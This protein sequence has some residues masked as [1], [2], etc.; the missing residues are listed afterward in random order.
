MARADRSRSRRP[1]KD[2]DLEA[3]TCVDLGHH[4]LHVEFTDAQP[5][6]WQGLLRG[7][8]HRILVCTTCSSSQT[9]ALNWEGRPIEGTRHYDLD[10]VYQQNAA[11]LGDTVWERRANYRREL[12]ARDQEAHLAAATA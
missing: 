11:L 12:M 10:E 2:V 9:M 7:S 5:R 3:C 8:R 6:K 4:W 1:H